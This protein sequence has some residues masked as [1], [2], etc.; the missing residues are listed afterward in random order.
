MKSKVLAGF[1]LLSGTLSAQ[2]VDPSPFISGARSDMN[3]LAG[4]YLNPIGRS[5]ATGLNNGWYTT[6]KTHKLGRFDLMLHPTLMI[7]PDVDRTFTINEARLSELELVDPSNNIAPTAAGE[8]EAGPELRYTNSG[9]SAN[10]N[11]PPGSGFR[12]F[13]FLSAQV[14]VGLVF[15]TDL[16]LRYIPQTSIPVINDVEVGLFGFGLKHDVL[17]WLPGDKIIP[18]DVSVMFSYSQ[19]NFRAP[20]D[21]GNGNDQ[22]IV[23]ESRGY[24]MRALVSKKITFLTVYGGVGY[25]NGLTDINING[26]FE[27]RDPNTNLVTSIEDPVAITAENN[28]MIGQLGLRLKFL[29]VVCLSADY[30]FGAYDAVTLG[31]GFSI[32]F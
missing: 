23:M 22:Q 25:N 29:W 11:A 16:S 5:L 2:F 30:T 26:T 7:I 21:G 8:D 31:T 13:P 19:L 1:L 20:L 18:V 3:Y 6:A 14:N 10:F 28:G 17:Q 24:T 32:D 9:I 27:Y 4:E 15:N 12:I